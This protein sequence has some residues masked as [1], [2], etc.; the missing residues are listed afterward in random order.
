MNKQILIIGHTP[1]QH[2]K[3]HHVIDT[4]LPYLQKMKSNYKFKK[5]KLNNIL[6][7]DNHEEKDMNSLINGWYPEELPFILHFQ[8][9]EI[10]TIH[11]PSFAFSDNWFTAISTNM[12][13]DS[14][15]YLEKYQFINYYNKEVDDTFFDILYNKQ[16]KCMKKDF[17]D[18]I[19]KFSWTQ[20]FVDDNFETTAEIVE[21]LLFQYSYTNIIFKK[22]IKIFNVY[23]KN[24]KLKIDDII[25]D[26]KYAIVKKLRR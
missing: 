24:F 11:I 7:I 14:T 2:V 13:K 8:F 4:L 3:E 5:N 12:H 22:N 26:K 25:E 17:E 10:Y 23:L 18:L 15:Y 21:A 20:Q 6:F 9:N 16:F 1:L 19:K